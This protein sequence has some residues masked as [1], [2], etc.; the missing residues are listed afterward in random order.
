MYS[1]LVFYKKRYF[2]MR[3]NK[4]ANP[5]VAHEHAFSGPGCSEN[6]SAFFIGDNIYDG[7][8]I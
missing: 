7:V 3:P 5:E 4:V 6:E 8:V 1:N 2:S